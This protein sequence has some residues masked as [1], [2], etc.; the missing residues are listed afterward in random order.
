MN[1]RSSGEDKRGGVSLQ[2]WTQI[3][4]SG[5]DKREGSLALSWHCSLLATILQALCLDQICYQLVL[6][7]LVHS[8][9]VRD[10]AN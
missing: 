5:E 10:D 1:W 7:E 3:R 9:P 4:L 8:K 6:V 2:R